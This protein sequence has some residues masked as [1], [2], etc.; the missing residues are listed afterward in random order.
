MSTKIEA[1]FNVGRFSKIKF[2]VGEGGV[3]SDMAMMW[4]LVDEVTGA[5]SRYNLYAPSD[6]S[7]D[8]INMH[9]ALVS[10]DPADTAPIVK[11]TCSPSQYKAWT[12]TWAV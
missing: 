1:A 2:T 10:A 6:H 11:S 8:T 7:A 5:S 9:Y 3:G 4:K 12:T